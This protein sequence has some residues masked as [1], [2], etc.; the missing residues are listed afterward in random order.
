[1][2]QHTTGEMAKQCGV[3]VRTV[4]YYDKRGILVPSELSEGGRR[5]YSEDDLRR[6][7]IICFLR[8]LGLPIDA[9][10]Q[11]LSEEDPGSVITILL[12]Q[13]EQALREEVREGNEKLERL[14]VLKRSLR[15]TQYFSVDSI[16]DIATIMSGKEKLKKIHRTMLFT[17]IP[18]SIFQ[19]ASIILWIVKGWWWLF[20]IWAVIAIPWG[21]WVSKYYFTHVAYI[22]PQCHEVFR[23]AFREAFFAPHTPRTRKLTCVKCGHHGFCVETAAEETK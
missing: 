7:R 18:V 22:C 3:T 15:E 16:G 20:V 19:W 12:A 17:G 5:L 11:L 13:Q 4:Q 2:S 8:E 10:G 21:I 1:M 9:I 6:L 14:E 23:P